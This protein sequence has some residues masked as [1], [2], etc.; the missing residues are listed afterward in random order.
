VWV[1]GSKRCIDEYRAQLMLPTARHS[2]A[3]SC[4]IMP[5]V[6]YFCLLMRL[7]PAAAA[8]ADDDDDAPAAAIIL[9][10]IIIIVI[11]IIII[12]RKTR[13]WALDRVHK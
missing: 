11:V 12:I 13:W 4:S 3:Y 10:I 7:L 9:F 2:T 5:N 1:I 6:T 8:A